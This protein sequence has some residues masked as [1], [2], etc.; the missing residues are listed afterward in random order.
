MTHFPRRARAFTAVAAAL[1]A[2]LVLGA[3]EGRT[4][5][6]TPGE[7]IAACVAIADGNVRFVADG[8]ACREGETA[9]T[10]DQGI[11]G[12]PGA[13]GAQGNPGSDGAPGERGPAG[14]PG[15]DGA[16]GD[17]GAPGERGERGEQGE[18]GPQGEQ[19]EQGPPGNPGPQGEQGAPGLLQTYQSVGFTV[20]SPGATQIVMSLIP[21][22]PGDIVEVY[23]EFTPYPLVPAGSCT[24]E[25]TGGTQYGP[26]SQ[27]LVAATP[28]L[29]RNTVVAT[30]SGD[31]AVILS[32]QPDDAP[33]VALDSASLHLVSF[34]VP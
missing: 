24:L 7:A 19:G 33:A 28:A 25:V 20:T 15:R 5:Q 12:A 2:A 22:S 10:V 21:V 8:V 23:A 31:L 6:P 27:A 9:M 3:C 16:P 29:M 1:A 11:D 32:C 34:P 18:P 13:P 17:P 26:A 14:E 4:T 30:T